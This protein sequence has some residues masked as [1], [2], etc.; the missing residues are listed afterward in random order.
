[1]PSRETACHDRCRMAEHIAKHEPLSGDELRG[2]LGWESQQ[3][4]D[5]VYSW[6]D[7]WFA[8]TVSGWELTEAGRTWLTRTRK[9]AELSA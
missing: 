6:P 7:R 5:A 2:A 3:F 8:L 4:L 9:G 1:M